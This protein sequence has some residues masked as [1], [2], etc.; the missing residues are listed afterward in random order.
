MQER[1]I[2]DGYEFPLFE[3]RVV[4]TLKFKVANII[5]NDRVKPAPSLF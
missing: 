1:F 3:E 2:N 5:D 4:I